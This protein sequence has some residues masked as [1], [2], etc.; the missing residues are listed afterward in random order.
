MYSN[1]FILSFIA[2]LSFSFMDVI[3][4][5]LFATVNIDFFSYMLWLDL[6][7]IFALVMFGVANHNFSLQF[8]KTNNY[9][10]ILLRS[11][12]SVGNTLCS[13]V[14]ISHLP[15]HL[16][17]ILAFMQP[18]IASF[19]SIIFKME[20]L[21][22]R[23]ILLIIFGFLGVLISIKVWDFTNNHIAMFAIAAGLGIAL[24]G[25][26]SGIVVKKY[27]VNDNAITIAIYNILLSILVACGYFLISA[28][29]IFIPDLSIAAMIL[30][31][32]TACAAGIVFFMKSYQTGEV[33]TI[34][35]LQYTQIIWGTFFGYLIFHEIPSVYSVIGAVIIIAVNTLNLKT[36]QQ[37]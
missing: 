29:H 1:G 23:K 6:A 21:K 28:K 3:N 30:G 33:Q 8:F 17:Y 15:F 36:E 34:S 9:K 32:G 35:Q 10:P 24:T 4:K 22:I 31:A 12:I 7:I 37:S 18:I 27:M 13:L 19:L 5:F 26:L 11:I 20:S 25:A 16:F 2:Y 14:A